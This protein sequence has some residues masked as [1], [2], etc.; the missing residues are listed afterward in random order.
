MPELQ[1][2]FCSSLSL[3]RLLAGCCFTLRSAASTPRRR[4]HH[5]VLCSI[6]RKRAMFFMRSTVPSQFSS[7]FRLRLPASAPFF[8]CV[9]IAAF[10]SAHSI[11]IIYLSPVRYMFPACSSLPG[12]FFRR[13]LLFRARAAPFRRLMISPSLC[14]SNSFPVYHIY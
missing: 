9:L 14:S 11:A 7:I 10:K 13:P 4:Q 5:H 6:F 2:R 12:K 8:T 3:F 1:R